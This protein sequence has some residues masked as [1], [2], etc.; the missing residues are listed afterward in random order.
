[1]RRRRVHGPMNK[2]LVIVG[3]GGFGREVH[4]WV[5]TSPQW[6]ER[7]DI[8][9]VVFVDDEVPAVPVSA[10]IISTLG[11]Y[12]PAD[13]DLVICAIGS[14][15][16]RRKIV[17]SLLSRNARMATFIH[18]RVVLGDNIV[19][20]DGAVVCPDAVL[21][22]DVKVGDH[23]HINVGCTIGHDVRIGDFVTL[24]SACNLT[25]NVTVE[26]GAFI[27]TAA[28]VI[29]GKRIGAGSFVGAGSVVLK[30]VPPNVTVFGNPG[31]VVGKRQ[32]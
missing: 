1:M 3:A 31:A 17:D 21:S 32:A 12:A 23:V 20:G 18:D 30:D 6:R 25:G 19:I 24:S 2:R 14:P 29:P 22:S 10:P 26:D 5:S 11:D 13:N 9:S 7:A 15:D 16:V 27:A 8:G 28:S 4:G